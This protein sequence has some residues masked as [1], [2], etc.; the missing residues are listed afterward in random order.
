VLIETGLSDILITDKSTVIESYYLLKDGLYILD[1]L[2]NVQDKNYTKS[3]AECVE[4]TEKSSEQIALDEGGGDE[5]FLPGMVF[6]EIP[7][8]SFMMGSNDGLSFNEPVHRV[9][10]SGIQMMTTEVTQRM[11]CEIM[12]SNPSNFKGD[13]LPVE[14]VSW[15]YCQEFIKKLNQ[16]DP[17]NNYRLPTEAEWEYACRAGTTTRF[18]CEDR[19]SELDRVGWYDGNS[20]NKTHPV[21]QKQPNAW[22]LYDMHGNVWE[23]CEDIWHSNYNGAPDDGRAWKSGGDSHLRVLRGGAWDVNSWSCGSAIR[24]WD[25]PNLHRTFIGFRICRSYIA[26]CT[27]KRELWDGLIFLIL[28]F[29]IVLLTFYLAFKWFKMKFLPTVREKSSK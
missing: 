14:S 28:E 1:S 27:P 21:G 12:G 13:N 3:E 16:L 7:G 8:G 6:V 5:G 9:T 2:R 25:R 4:I 24:D 10:I 22:G 23:W 17:G 20:G 18:Y 15:D 29:T 11:W 19:N 26:T